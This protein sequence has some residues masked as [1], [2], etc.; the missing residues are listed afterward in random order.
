MM[1]C[2]LPFGSWLYLG[3]P[4]NTKEQEWPIVGGLIIHTGPDEFM[5][6]DLLRIFYSFG[7]RFREISGIITRKV[8]PVS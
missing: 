4:P 1:C 5:V 7:T 6:A 8:S 2:L 3:W